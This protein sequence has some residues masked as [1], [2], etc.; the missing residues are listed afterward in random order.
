M[1]PSPL[2]SIILLYH[3]NSPKTVVLILAD[4]AQKGIENLYPVD[5]FDILLRQPIF[6]RNVQIAFVACKPFIGK[7]ESNKQICVEL[8]PGTNCCCNSFAQ[9][10]SSRQLLKDL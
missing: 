10:K 1:K 7:E 4:F 6:F 9:E 5:L 8:G 3:L 2:L